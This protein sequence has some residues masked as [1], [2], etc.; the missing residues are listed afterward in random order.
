MKQLNHFTF[1][2]DEPRPECGFSRNAHSAWCVPSLLPSFMNKKA[3]DNFRIIKRSID[4]HG[5]VYSFCSKC[6]QFI[7][8]GDGDVPPHT[9]SYCKQAHKIQNYSLPVGHPFSIKK[10]QH[11]LA[12]QPNVETNRAP[13]SNVETDEA[14]TSI[15]VETNE[16]MNLY[17][18]SN[19][20]D[21]MIKVALKIKS[22]LHKLPSAALASSSAVSS[23]KP[24]A[25]MSLA[26]LVVKPTSSSSSAV[27]IADS[28]NA[29]CSSS[30]KLGGPGTYKD[31]EV[32]FD[33]DVAEGRGV[34]ADDVLGVENV[35]PANLVIPANSALGGNGRPRRAGLCL[36]LQ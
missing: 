20:V 25:A 30:A 2:T 22:M 10:L 27:L 6:M 21:S 14:P 3:D 17:G 23:A 19:L 33:F 4:D 8:E 24:L 16:S 31:S 1:I 36:Q 28:S 15:D 13:T 35:R 29:T 18:L 12:S 5:T 34:G 11:D 7:C 32:E 26:V 9:K